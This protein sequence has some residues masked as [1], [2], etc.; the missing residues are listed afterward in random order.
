[1]LGGFFLGSLIFELTLMQFD[2]AHAWGFM[3]LTICG[4]IAGLALSF[5]YGKEVIILST[6]LCGGLGMMRGTC[7]FFPEETRFPSVESI[8]RSVAD[9]N[10]D[11]TLAWQFWLYAS[12]W[13]VFF[14]AFTTFQCV[15]WLHRPIS[16]KETVDTSL[17]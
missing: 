2:F 3:T 4:V 14:A 12:E 16:A 11:Y 6:S 7:F 8:V 13:L 1:M 15:R 10:K 5:R 9:G 17:N